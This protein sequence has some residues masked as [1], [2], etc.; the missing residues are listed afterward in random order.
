MAVLRFL[1]HLAVFQ[2]TPLPSCSTPSPSPPCIRIH[3]RPPPPPWVT[4]LALHAHTPRAASCPPP[5]T[6]A[7]IGI[8]LWPPTERSSARGPHVCAAGEPQL[9]GGGG[10]ASARELV[11][12]GLS[13]LGARAVRCRCGRRAESSSADADPETPVL[14]LDVAPELLAYVAHCGRAFDTGRVEE[15]YISAAPAREPVANVQGVHAAVLIPHEGDVQKRHWCPSLPSIPSLAQ[16]HFSPSAPPRVPIRPRGNNNENT[17]AGTRG[18]YA[19]SGGGGLLS[20]DNLEFG[21]RVLAPAAREFKDLCPARTQLGAWGR[22]RRTRRISLRPALIPK[23]VFAGLGS[24]LRFHGVCSKLR[25]PGAE[26][27]TH[28]GLGLHN[29]R[30]TRL[31]TTSTCILPAPSTEIHQACAVTRISRATVSLRTHKYVS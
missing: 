3:R 31:R 12:H 5:P 24:K 6:Q 25:F 18:A 19:F 1:L 14:M 7:R 16:N 27:Q 23:H 29:D 20:G 10:A 30:P 15:L 21:V 22:L 2:Y 17:N 11:L 8:G 4:H 28:A 9:A 26:H 13:A